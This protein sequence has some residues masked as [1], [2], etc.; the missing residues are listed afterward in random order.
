MKTATIEKNSSKFSEKSLLISSSPSLFSNSSSRSSLSTR[1][2]Y[3]KK[4]HALRS[5]KNNLKRF[6]MKSNQNFPHKY[7]QDN[8]LNRFNQIKSNASIRKNFDFIHQNKN[9]NNNKDNNDDDDD[10][11]D[12]DDD[13]DDDDDK[14]DKDKRHNDS[15]FSENAEET[16]EDDDDDNDVDSISNG[17]IDFDTLKISYEKQELIIKELNN[18]LNREEFLAYQKK[19]IIIDT[20]DH[21]FNDTIML[22]YCE[23]LV[24][25][26]WIC[27]CGES[28]NS[29]FWSEG[30]FYEHLMIHA[31]ESY[32]CPLCLDHF[33]TDFDQH[34]EHLE[35]IDRI[36]TGSDVM[37][38]LLQDSYLMLKRWCD[39]FFNSQS[40]VN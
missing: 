10:D 2:I 8:H 27:F 36:E 39:N 29:R 40:I 38:Y 17:S 16:S 21:N 31:T 15:D 18:E 5:R 20:E 25:K 34:R 32:Q 37:N 26:E 13:D 28:F 7:W 3:R 9:E 30:K 35:Q 19:M 12:N 33:S 4:L 22:D 24:D 6:E 11:D 1:S 23:N 14:D